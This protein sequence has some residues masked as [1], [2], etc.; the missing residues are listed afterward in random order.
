MQKVHSCKINRIFYDVQYFFFNSFNTLSFLNINYISIHFLTFILNI[1][2]NDKY[3][4]NYCAKK[5]YLKLNKY[6]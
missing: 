4:N 1:I 2:G 3:D 6:M 5:I